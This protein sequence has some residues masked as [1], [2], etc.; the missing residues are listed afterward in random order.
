M[1]PKDRICPLP[2]VLSICCFQ[3]PL[4]KVL[5]RFL[6]LLGIVSMKKLLFIEMGGKVS[7]RGF[8]N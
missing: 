1:L 6:S 8:L 4:L 3:F 5:M 7:I 2:L